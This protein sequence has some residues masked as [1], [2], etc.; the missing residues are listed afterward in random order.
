M[1]LLVTL[2]ENGVRVLKFDFHLSGE[3]DLNPRKQ[4][5]ILTV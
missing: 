5:D 4:C 1:V 3:R 2:L